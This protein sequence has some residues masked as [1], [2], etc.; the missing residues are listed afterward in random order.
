M[1]TL[2]IGGTQTGGTSKTLTFAGQDNQGRVRFA[3]PEHTALSQR[4]M[5]VGTKARPVTKTSLGV[6]EATVDF[7]L[8]DAEVSE[9]CCGTQQGGVYVNLKIRHDLNQPVS[10]VDDALKYLQGAAFAAFLADA[11]KKGLITITP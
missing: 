6:Q 2:T 1:S 3:F 9:G 4:L 8:R 10:L 7:V 5:T 11:I